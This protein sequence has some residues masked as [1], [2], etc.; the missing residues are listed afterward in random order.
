M[1]LEIERSLA[2]LNSEHSKVTSVPGGSLHVIASLPHVPAT[3][4]TVSRRAEE[5]GVCEHCPT[6]ESVISHT[7]M[8]Q[9]HLS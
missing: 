1:C 2:S 3:S 4:I 6:C 8:C 5:C 7:Y 9:Q